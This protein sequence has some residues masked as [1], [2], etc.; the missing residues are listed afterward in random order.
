MPAL[1]FDLIQAIVNH[2]LRFE[3]DETV[4]PSTSPGLREA[5]LALVT[6]YIEQL[7]MLGLVLDPFPLFGAAPNSSSTCFQVGG[8]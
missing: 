8:N 4:D 7:S 1:Q 3:R 2:G 5:G 6:A